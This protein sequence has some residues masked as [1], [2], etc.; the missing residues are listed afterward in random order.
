MLKGLFIG[1]LDSP[2][3]ISDFK[4]D[5]NGNSKSNFDCRETRWPLSNPLNTENIENGKL[6]IPTFAMP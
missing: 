4:L 6:E 1:H 2:V 5:V 3:K